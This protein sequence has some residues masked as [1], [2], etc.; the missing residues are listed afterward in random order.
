MDFY[1]ARK[2]REATDI[3][4]PYLIM[5]QK[6]W[7]TSFLRDYSRFIFSFVT[8]VDRKNNFSEQRFVKMK[9]VL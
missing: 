4:M 7:V 3:K 6:I 5:P 1:A 8:K 2:Y 9:M